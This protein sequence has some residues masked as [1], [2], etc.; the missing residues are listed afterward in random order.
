MSVAAEGSEVSGL[1]VWGVSGLAGLGG[2]ASAL[3]ELEEGS[4]GWSSSVVVVAGGGLGASS[5]GWGLESC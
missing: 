2:G 5:A 3:G 1:C 4:G